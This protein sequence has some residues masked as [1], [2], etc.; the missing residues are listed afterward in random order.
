[1]AARVA[2]GSP[3]PRVRAG[4]DL[5]LL[6]SYERDRTSPALTEA[7]LDL[8]AG[9]DPAVGAAA[10]RLID[11]LA[12]WASDLSAAAA[13]LIGAAGDE[14]SRRVF[15]TCCLSP[16]SR[17]QAELAAEAGVSAQRVGQ[18]ARTAARRVRAALADAP[19]PLPWA[20]RSAGRR[21][22]GITTVAGAQAVAAALG[23][24]PGPPA[25]LVLWLA[26]P[27][28]PVP[29]R[30]G[31]LAVEP[32]RAVRRSTACLAGDGGVRRLIDVRSELSD[33]QIA[34]ERLGGWLSA[35]AAA[36]VHDLVVTV[37]GRLGNALE[38]LLDAH[39]EARSLDDLRTDMAAAGRV[40]D[41]DA[42][43]AA[44]RARRFVATTDGRF[45]LRAWGPV[46]PGRPARPV[47]QPAGHLA[48]HPIRPV[49]RAGRS[50]GDPAGAR[51]WLRVVVD[52]EALR[53][54]DADIPTGLIDGLGLGPPFRRSFSS[55]WGPVVLAWE[56][57]GPRRGSLR[58]V[59]LALG[60]RPGDT[61]LLGFAPAGDLAV[62]L[63]RGNGPS[64]AA[65][66]GPLP[67]AFPSGHD[68]P[69]GGTG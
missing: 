49:R 30:A 44:L 5:S 43:S 61:L 58:A 39:G 10:G 22:G 6:L 16:R 4:T 38:R 32:V 18:I 27:Y 25:E 52:A 68:H 23:A 28:S 63:H 19:A 34:P 55:R 64:T 9:D 3:Q 8:R 11:A 66:P 65:P 17:S 36:V 29:G 40:V 51:V 21:L 31:W 59:A 45:A 46:G 35:N 20:V 13:W 42:L 67:L 60:A 26:G 1:M 24:Q 62:E 69:T 53:G 57:T 56:G 2:K 33:L 7:L 54:G 12:P 50:G 48:G 47:R 14:R 41:G 37:D 15:E